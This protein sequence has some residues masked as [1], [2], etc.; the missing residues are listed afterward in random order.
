M[1]KKIKATGEDPLFFWG[2]FGLVCLSVLTLT[3]CGYWVYSSNAQEIRRAQ[4]EKLRAVADLK[5]DQILAWRQERLAD[6]QVNAAGVVRL[7]SLQWLEGDVDEAVAAAANEQM[8]LL[9]SHYNYT[10]VILVAADG[11]AISTLTSEPETSASAIIPVIERVITSG[12]PTLGDMFRDPERNAV[13]LDTTAPIMNDAKE[14]VAALILRMDMNEYLYPLIQSWPTPSPSAETLLIRVEEDS[15]LFL[16][17]LR[18]SSAQPLTSRIPL[19]N[20]DIP[21]VQTALHR[22]GLFEGRDY[23]G[24]PVLSDLRALPGTNWHMIA[25]L[26]MT[27]VLAEAHHRGWM[28]FL[29]TLLGIA[30][31]GLVVVSIG[32]QRRKNIFEALYR[33]ERKEREAQ[34]EIRATLYGIGDG[35]IAVDAACK[36]TRMNPVAETL[37]GWCEAEAI[38]RPLDEVFRI[39][40][41]DTRAEVENPAHRV[42]REGRI[43]GLANSAVLIAKDGSE[44]SI[45]DS[46]APIYD[47]GNVLAGVVLVFRDQTRERAAARMLREREMF[48][49]AILNGIAANIAVLDRNGVITAVNRAWEQFAYD[50]NAGEAVA[51]GIGLNYLDVA[52]NAQGADTEYA[53]ETASGIEALLAEDHGEFSIEYPCHSPSEKRWF[54]L[55]AT[56]LKSDQG[57]AVLAHINI[58]SRKLA[59]EAL[60]ASERRYRDM[61]EN[62]HAVMLIINPDGGAIV[63]ANPAA[64]QFY[65]W[66]RQRLATMRI[67]DINIL[68]PEEIQ[69]EMNLARNEERQHFYFQHRLADGTIRDVEVSSGS[70]WIDEQ[71]LL[72]S[73]VHDITERKK[74]EAAL[75]LHDEHLK[76]LAKILQNPAETTQELLDYA[77][78][79]AINLTASK[80]GY[81]YFYDD[82]RKLFIL[83]SWSRDVMP[84]CTI[85]NPQ[86][87][88]ELEKTG[89]W[90]EVVRQR[91]PIVL[92]D[93]QAD[94]PHK[95][96]YPDG[97]V[98]LEKYMSVP[99]VS[100]GRIAAVIAVANKETDYTETD[101]L[102]L[103]LLMDGVWKTAER[104]RAEEQLRESEARFRLFYEQAPVAYQSLDEDGHIL[105]VNDAWLTALGYTREAVVGT[106]FVSF[107]A[108]DGPI[109]FEEHFA[110]LKTKG[111]CHGVE[112]TLRCRDN[113]TIL[114]S[115]EARVSREGDGKILITH[116]VF[117]NITERKL[118]EEQFLHAQKME[119]V[120]RLAGGVAHDF[121]NMLGVIIG[122][123]EAAMQHTTPDSAIP[124]DLKA[125]LDAA[126]RSAG[127]THQLL[128][129]ARKQTVSPVALWLNDSLANMRTMLQRLIGEDI[130][131][132]WKPGRALWSV[133]IDPSQLDQVL[134]NLAVN[135]RDAMEGSGQLIVETANATFDEDW[136]A[137]H[138][139]YALGDYV[140]LAVSD[141]GVGMDAYVREHI[142]EPFFT[143]KGLGKGTGL[144]LA[145]IYGIVKQNGGLIDVQSESGR[146]T[147]IKI[148]LPRTEAAVFVENKGDGAGE[149]PTG[150]TETI[151]LVE[152]E[153]AI[154]NLARTVLQKNGYTVLTSMSPVEAVSIF[155]SYEHTID[156][157]I[158]DVVM[159]GMNGNELR[160]Q[161]LARSPSIQVLFMSGYTA[162]AI[163]QHGL[164]E[165]G[166]H[167][168]QKP[169][170]TRDLLQK[171]REALQDED[172]N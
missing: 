41:E 64:E 141:T 75:R 149:A 78:A 32:S 100:D 157:L 133:K 51:A 168:L 152:D 7:F 91:R 126:Q 10:A 28:L 49:R 143:T 151:L 93:F 169:F 30:A 88:Y 12:E 110:L 34:E 139:H 6:A 125:I 145:T 116:W 55:F 73:I 109:H 155:D 71:P 2:M 83:N 18:H 58:T 57:G 62:N 131:L 112:F 9:Q 65:G 37:T 167:F 101:V 17:P 113:S 163:A 106:S 161:I 87:C 16:N 160:E 146:G 122:H 19:E 5:A 36:V 8:Q 48:S 95:K 128:A 144:G 3:A 59:E 90:G 40:H 11:R 97:H 38:G 153:A 102:Q 137:R 136:C 53:A 43:V 107:L 81:I 114:A 119:S 86:T 29:M 170:M 76:S 111:E 165:E 121:N 127:L 35:V 130:E 156:L 66:T 69:E 138:P 44:R 150:G 52:R 60:V 154:L 158:S 15:V 39:V 140:M 120:G 33:V 98:R 92:N 13:F 162:D 74:A 72:Y 45:A 1:A 47:Q 148:F 159:P 54:L 129:F 96:G 61:F 22:Q 79:E 89:I 56:P 104:K 42:L 108:D 117:V 26:D 164:L 70:V 80:I 46:G 63:D 142:F 124:G 172:Q 134:A 171:V 103:S 77:L 82:A 27:E 14:A 84:E 99:V 67:S 94:N 118:L 147:T 23:R 68:T 25:K 132:V 24:T 31:T 20:T 166:I 4:H 135:A 85:V 123:A 105:A 115:F 21:A 50:N